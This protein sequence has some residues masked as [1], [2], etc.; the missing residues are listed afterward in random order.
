MA[1]AHVPVSTALLLAG[2][3]RG[4]CRCTQPSAR[5]ESGVAFSWSCPG[6]DCPLCP[7]CTDTQ[8]AECGSVWPACGRPTHRRRFWELR[9]AWRAPNATHLWALPPVPGWA[10]SA[11]QGSAF[12]VVR[13]Q[14]RGLLCPRGPP[15]PRA[16]RPRCSHRRTGSRASL[17]AQGQA[18]ELLWFV[19]WS[20]TLCTEVTW[21]LGH[22][23]V[24]PGAGTPPPVS[25]GQ[26]DSHRD[27]RDG[28]RFWPGCPVSDL[29]KE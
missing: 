20:A 21:V 13:K 6:G 14:R 28:T 19:D 3:P 15:P 2:R 27:G 18:C 17:V 16:G 4:L 23:S 1:W 11:G 8:S 24:A 26:C 22:L 12:D 25:L 9:A 5:V 7:L 10:A 29:L